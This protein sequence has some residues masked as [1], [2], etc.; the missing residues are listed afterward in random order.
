MAAGR[1]P[2]P[3]K[4]VCNP[5]T[6]CL[7]VPASGSGKLGTMLRCHRLILACAIAITWSSSAAAATITVQ[8]TDVW[9]DFTNC[10]PG[11]CGGSGYDCTNQAQ[12]D[13]ATSFVDP[14]P[15]GSV[16]RQVTVSLIG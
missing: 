15:P 3:G 13:S 10:G 2:D 9:N 11:L 4:R 14:T 16:V 6:P 7:A 12:Y 1:P 8:L 5:R